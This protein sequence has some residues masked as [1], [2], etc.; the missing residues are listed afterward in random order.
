MNNEARKR[1]ARRMASSQVANELD[2]FGYSHKEE[3]IDGLNKGELLKAAELLIG[4]A[5]ERESN[6][7]L[8]EMQKNYDNWKKG[9]GYHS[10][11][12]DSGLPALDTSQVPKDWPFNLE[13]WSF[14]NH[15]GMLV[16]AAAYIMAEAQ[17]LERRHSDV[18]NYGQAAFDPDQL[19]RL[20]DT[21]EKATKIARRNWARRSEAPILEVGSSPAYTASASVPVIAD[22]TV[23]F[24]KFVADIMLEGNLNDG[25]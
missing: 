3:A 15:R 10:E 19:K 9:K 16:R 8:P 6:R 4:K 22:K 7:N 25:T 11:L 17:R 21:R 2:E 13:E 23:L 5:Y 1:R 18:Y 12:R 14:Y 20:K 24:D